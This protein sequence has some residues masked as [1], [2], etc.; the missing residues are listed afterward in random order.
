MHIVD[1]FLRFYELPPPFFVRWQAKQ[2]SSDWILRFF[3]REVG[4]DITGKHNVAEIQQ[5]AMINYRKYVITATNDSIQNPYPYIASNRHYNYFLQLDGCS[6]GYASSMFIIY[7]ICKVIEGYKIHELPV[8]Q[9]N[10][11]PKYADRSDYALV[12][13]QMSFYASCF[14]MFWRYTKDEEI[15]ESRLAMDTPRFLFAIGKPQ[16]VI[17][18]PYSNDPDVKLIRQFEQDAF[19]KQ[20]LMVKE[21]L[22][23][24]VSYWILY[25][26]DMMQRDINLVAT[27]EFV[28]TQYRE[29]MPRNKSDLVIA[30]CDTAWGA[31]QYAELIRHAIR[32][33][34]RCAL[35]PPDKVTQTQQMTCVDAAP[36]SVFAEMKVDLKQFPSETW[37]IGEQNNCRL[38]EVDGDVKASSK[39][40][41]STPS[42][43]ATDL[44]LWKYEFEQKSA[45]FY[46]YTFPRL[47]ALTAA[48]RKGTAVVKPVEDEIGLRCQRCREW[49]FNKT[50]RLIPSPFP[51]VP[52]E[53]AAIRPVHIGRQRIPQRTSPIE[54]CPSLLTSL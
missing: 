41:K 15:S 40:A 7:A 13:L 36:R 12:Y 16:N 51:T 1:G 14:A 38:Y 29:L 19:R 42:D 22:V 8:P 25:E 17:P 27:A 9:P 24:V 20:P 48:I 32:Y 26:P 11:Y 34:Q 3:V 53:P 31:I 28:Y 49:T 23:H 43:Y 18:Y 4:T 2:A 10:F 54:C 47:R 35:F 46:F 5:N 33:G 30:D 6:C 44:F 21:F 45:F 37:D 39:E 50:M 52:P